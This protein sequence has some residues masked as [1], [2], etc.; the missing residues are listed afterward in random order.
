[1]VDVWGGKRC[2]GAPE[3]PPIMASEEQPARKSRH[4]VKHTLS[5]MK[6][7]EALI[8]HGLRLRS[9]P[10]WFISSNRRV[11][12]HVGGIVESRCLSVGFDGV[13]V[14]RGWLRTFVFFIWSVKVFECVLQRP[15][16]IK[17]STQ[18]II[19]VQFIKPSLNILIFKVLVTV[20]LNMAPY[21]SN[22]TCKMF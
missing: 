15:Y 5:Q 16:K 11:L 4:V 17:F 12:V 2:R 8:V 14:S 1:M 3:K 13:V 22:V 10:S 18:T 7:W 20:Q 19:S 21:P 6:R 9:S